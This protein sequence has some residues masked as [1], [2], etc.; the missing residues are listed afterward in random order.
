MMM[1]RERLMFVYH[2]NLIMCKLDSNGLLVDNERKNLR[3]KD[4]INIKN[5]PPGTKFLSHI[6]IITFC[7]VEKERQ[8]ERDEPTSPHSMCSV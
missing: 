3:A 8:G 2:R 4:K 6:I 7:D 1:R 5:I